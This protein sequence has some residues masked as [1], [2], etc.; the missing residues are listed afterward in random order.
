MEVSWSRSTSSS[1]G[2]AL[3]GEDVA[4][5]LAETAL[6]VIGIDQ[7]LVGGECPYFGCIPSKMMIQASNA[8]AAGRRIPAL[9][10]DSRVMA[11]WAPGAARVR[12]EATDDWNDQV[13]VDRFEGKGGRFV[14]G[15][16]RV[17]GPK[18]RKI[19]ARAGIPRPSNHA[20]AASGSTLASSQQPQPSQASRVGPSS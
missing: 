1:S 2:W 16:G 4:E 8:L 18:C 10:G 7:R 6:E 9:A 13:A 17:T 15:H 12:N 20:R 3:A 5:R 14:R 11:D 19:T